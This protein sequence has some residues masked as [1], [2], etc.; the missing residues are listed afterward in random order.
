MPVAW[1]G[2]RKATP[3]HKSTFL[4]PRKTRANH[5]S[6]GVWACMEGLRP[7]E[8]GRPYIA[9]MHA[10]RR[11]DYWSVGMQSQQYYGWRKSAPTS[12]A[13]S[14]CRSAHKARDGETRAKNNNASKQSIMGLH[15][16]CL[17]ARGPLRIQILLQAT[18][19][20]AVPPQTRRLTIS[21]GLI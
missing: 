16:A 4:I 1:P 3:S 11:S 21:G 7:Q 14:A 20:G 19:V 17:A 6:I 18:K 12:P 13:R 10:G 8:A 9:A 5:F 15:C 2:P